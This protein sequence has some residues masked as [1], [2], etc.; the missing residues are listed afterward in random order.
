MLYPLADLQEPMATLAEEVHD[1]DE[2]GWPTPSSSIR[3]R[4]SCLGIAMCRS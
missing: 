3:G 1:D 4:S 2:A